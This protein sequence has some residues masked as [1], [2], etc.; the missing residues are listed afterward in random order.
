MTKRTTRDRFGPD[1]FGPDRFAWI[2]DRLGEADRLQLRRRLI[3]RR[4]E[5]P[6][7]IEGDRRLVNF[8]SNDYLGIASQTLPDL[9]AADGTCGAGASP[10]VCGFTPL[11]AELCRQLAELECAESAVLFPSGFAACSGTIA[12]LAERDD[13]VLSDALNHASLIDG[14]RLAKAERFIYPHRDH[15]AVAALLASHRHRFRRAFVVT[16][17]VFSMDGTR[18]PLA[19]LADL[20][21]AHDATLIVD[22][23][24]ATG[25]LGRRGAGL[26]DELG[27]EQRVPVRIGTLSK[28]IGV[29][30]GFVVGPRLVTDYLLQK[31]RPL[32]YST[33]A[34]PVVIAA[35]LQGLRIVRDE[36][37]RRRRVLQLASSLVAR[38]NQL[39]I[40]AIDH[41][42]PIVPVV[43]GDADRTLAAAK[44]LADSGFYV[45]A[46]RPPTVPPGTARLRIS[47][48]AAHSEEM[49]ESLCDALAG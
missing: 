27:L 47:L 48:S 7:L 12:A 49:I 2:A 34:P 14:C 28:A 30:G 3:P 17:S 41:G 26:C 21:D 37:Q 9:A 44:N 40:R 5:G 35:A 6:Y 46:I 33:A 10:L 13:L 43:L 23:A 11:H 29:H 19:E 32:I 24:H 25:V 18:A 45:P 16:D 42:T 8:G 15:G 22:E 20:A 4:H 36:P 31:S 1:R 38:L 39:G